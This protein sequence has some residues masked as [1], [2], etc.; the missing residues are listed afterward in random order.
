[1][2]KKLLLPIGGVVIIVILALIVF[3]V[4]KNLSNNTAINATNTLQSEQSPENNQ[5]TMLDACS[6]VTDKM[7]K[8]NIKID[9]IK[10][11]STSSTCTYEGTED[12]SVTT[13]S[14]VVVQIYSNNAE[15]YYFPNLYGATNDASDLGSKGF[16]QT[17][18]QGNSNAQVIKN[19][20]LLMLTIY[21]KN[22]YTAENVKALLAGG[23]LNL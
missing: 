10:K 7:I 18:T 13:K 23:A 21:S 6:V 17:P 3:F 14:F 9:V 11:S 22:N 16:Y 8:D 1:M 19:G 5:T 20:K 12:N 2:N 15:M 4:A